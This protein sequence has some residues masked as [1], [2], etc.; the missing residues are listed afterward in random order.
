MTTSDYDNIIQQSSKGAKEI[1]SELYE[2]FSKKFGKVVIYVENEVQE[3]LYN[4]VD[5]EI[6]DPSHMI[7]KDRN[8]VDYSTNYTTTEKETF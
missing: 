3:F 7:K 1:H 4:V 5:E 2:V 6:F 8:I